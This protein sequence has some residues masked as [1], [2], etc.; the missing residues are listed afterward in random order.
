MSHDNVCFQKV[1]FPMKSVGAWIDEVEIIKK[2]KVNTD[3][4]SRV[5]A[6]SQTELILARAVELVS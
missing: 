5:S 2:K 4:T 6:V 1:A 3:Q